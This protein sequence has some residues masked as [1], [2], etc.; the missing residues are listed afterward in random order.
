MSK[1][2]NPATGTLKN[3][4][5]NLIRFAPLLPILFVTACGSSG[6][7]ADGASATDD[8]AAV[9]TPPVVSIN[10]PG[11]GFSESQG[12]AVT[13]SAVATDLE[14][15]DIDDGISWNSSIDGDLGS[16]PMLSS[17]LSAGAHTISAQVTDS[18]NQMS[19][20][21]VDVIIEPDTAPPTGVNNIGAT[22]GE[23]MT[24]ILRA[25]QLAYTDD[26]SGADK[27]RFTITTT[28]TSGYLAFA[29]APNL[30][31]DSFSQS[32]ID[33]DR[34]IYAHRRGSPP[35]DSFAFDV[36]DGLGNVLAGQLFDIQVVPNVGSFDLSFE[37][38]S[39]ELTWSRPTSP[40]IDSIN[41]FK[42]ISADFP[43]GAN[44]SL[45]ASVDPTSPSVSDAVIATPTGVAEYFWYTAISTGPDGISSQGKIAGLYCQAGNCI[46]APD[47]RDQ[48]RIGS[49]ADIDSVRQA[50]ITETWGLDSLPARQPDAVRTM[51]PTEGGGGNITSLRRDEITI[52]MGSSIQSKLR[53]YWPFN[54]NNNLVIYHQGHLGTTN[55]RL[56]VIQRFLDDGYFVL[57]ISMPLTGYNWLGTGQTC[58]AEA[59]DQTIAALNRPMHFFLEPVA[60]GLNYVDQSFSFDN[61]FM[62]GISGGGWTTTVYAAL[63]TR[64]RASYS[65]AGSYPFYVTDQIYG[66]PGLGDFE[67]INPDFY[68]HAS[69]LDLY[70]MSA[71]NSRTSLIYNEFDSCCFEGTYSNSFRSYVEQRAT[72]LGGSIEVFIDDTTTTHAISAA[73]LELISNDIARQRLP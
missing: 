51:T 24:I 18:D 13:F 52:D 63:D 50:L 14:D 59:H 33:G 48:T 26:N 49:T 69:Y 11:P 58:C 4:K 3:K 62:T 9:L 70:L 34:V 35:T 47:L 57:E 53:L 15:G 41:I 12:V 67:Q 61:I 37:N 27:I 56:P 32:D 20:A 72:Q 65:V 39:V 25:D 2:T 44:G 71:E 29:D 42:S 60:V 10:T 46:T 23:G 31:V 54:S 19:A 17:T 66:Q 7:G 6:G 1:K 68:A 30:L 64:I 28:P 43:T 5:F 36:T 38:N 55:E 73:A 45:L 8:P 40:L 22:V 16:G 21:E